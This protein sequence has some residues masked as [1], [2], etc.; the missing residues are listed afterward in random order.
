M[1]RFENKIRRIAKITDSYL[2]SYI[3]KQDTKSHLLKPI[4][5]GLFSGG[6]RF[7]SKIIFD[8]G[9]IFNINYNL[10]KIISAAVESIHS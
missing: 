3:K 10:L 1:S 7:R 2:H 4:S 8:S 6:K 9:K 5:Y